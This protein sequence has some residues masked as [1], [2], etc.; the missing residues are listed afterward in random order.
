MNPAYEI[1][2]RPAAAQD[3]QQIGDLRWRLKTEDAN[4]SDPLERAAFIKAFVN[5]QT[6][7]ATFLHWVAEANGGL[8]AAMS[9][10]SV[11]KLLAPHQRPSALGYLTNCY[12]LPSF[13]RCG[14][15]GRL[16]GIITEWAREQEFE[17]LLVWPSDESY[18]FYG[19]F[20]FKDLRDPLVL[21]L[22]GS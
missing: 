19:R 3:L 21:P 17:L 7:S 6:Q 2:F 14:V 11:P 5:D 16:L 4:D 13:R 8:I 9:I 12:T 18:D 15:G 10:A 20:G 1:V 22:N